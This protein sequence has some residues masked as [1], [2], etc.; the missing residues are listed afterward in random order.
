MEYHYE[1]KSVYFLICSN[2]FSH[3][4]FIPQKKIT[5]YM[6]PITAVSLRWED[7]KTSTSGG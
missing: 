4:R 2:I 7:L 1:I 3:A 6:V 5:T